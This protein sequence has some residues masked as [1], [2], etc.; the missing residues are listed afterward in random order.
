MA[1]DA[2]QILRQ[3]Y[4][5]GAEAAQL[6]ELAEPSVVRQP[7]AESGKL[8]GTSFVVEA[9]PTAELM[10]SM[11]ELSFQ[12]EEKETKRAGERKMGEM[13]GPR[14]AMVK[15]VEAWMAMM[16]D[17]PG[18]NFL[19]GVLRH[20]RAAFAS[21]AGM[22]ADELLKELARG[23]TDPS[24]Q[25]AMLDIL[26]QAFGEGEDAMRALVRDAK[27]R[28]S[29]AKGPEIRAGINLAEEIN[30]RATTPEE[31]RE[32][33]DMYRGE[34]VGFTKPQDCF[35]SL[36]AARGAEGLN[37]A[38]EFLIAGCGADLMSSA[39]SLDAA[40]LGRI[41]TDLQCVQV[42]QTVLEAL[43]ALGIRMGKQFGEKCLLDGE[44]MTGRVLDFTEQA[45]VASPGIAAFIGDC[46]MKALLARMDFARELVGLF[47]KL[48]PRLFAREGDRQRL[49]DA[50]QEHLD[51][52]ITEEND[53]ADE[54]GQAPG[55]EAQ[56]GAA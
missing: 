32:L 37:D 41:L 30:E 28:L 7:V 33:R 27:A 16:P 20:L 52:L 42:L 10:D 13:Q 36:L 45:F 40:A 47:R 17:M 44:Q 38:L 8:M 31:M 51:D 6:R 19:A 5:A 24:H 55:H 11:E 25:F 4:A 34:V 23:S 56:E 2:A 12:F 14:S 3:T 48:S 43:S 22:S 39:P 1:F 29:E 18:R 15:A 35:R 26:E 49:V 9:D 46:G 53:S 50:A 21:G 54:G